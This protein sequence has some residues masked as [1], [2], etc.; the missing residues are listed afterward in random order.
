[1]IRTHRIEEVNVE[2]TRNVLETC[3]KKGITR[4]VYLSTNGVVFGGKEIENGD[5]TLPYLPSNYYVSSYDRTKSIAEQLVL[6]NNG[7]IVENGHGSLLSTCA[8]RCPIVY[9][10]A[11]EKYLD[12]IISYAR[13]GLFLFKIGDTSSK[14]DWIYVD[15]IVYALMLATTDLLNE[16]PRAAGKAYFVSDD[17]PINFFEVLR[18][19]LKNLDYDL[20]NSS[21]SI[22]FVVLL[23]KIEVGVTH[24]YSI[25]KAKEELG[26]EP[27][28]QPEEAMTKTISYF[29]D[30]KRREVDGPSI[31][32]WTFCVIGLPSIISVAWLPDIGPIPFFRVIAMFIFRSMLVLRIA[33]GIVVTAHVSEAVYALWLARRVDPKNAKAWFWRTLLLATFSLRLLLKRAKEV[34]Q[35]TLREG[36]LTNSGS[37]IA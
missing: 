14:T 31:Y 11:E 1:M 23:G 35:S 15:N 4:L 6:E 9:G 36:L 12:R 37:S 28:T 26:Y 13:L 33:S 20:P 27:T 24:Y 2:G 21:L 16:H 17:N 18:P 19:L 10:P 5:E 34:K 32:A 8:I 7:R 22:S 30:K 3:V 29:K 25:G